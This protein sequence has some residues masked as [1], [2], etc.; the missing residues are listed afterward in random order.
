MSIAVKDIMTPDPA[1]C[2]PDS[3]L[4]EVAKLMVEHDCGEIPVVASADELR[5]IGVITDRD[6]VVRTLGADLDPMQRSVRHCMSTPCITVSA[7]ATLED[8]CE[9]M[10]SQQIRRVPV[11]DDDGTLVGIVAL[12]DIVNHS[13]RR[14]A[15]EVIK[16][17]SQ[18]AGK[19]H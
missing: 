4:T 13:S 11:V 12:A 1:V 7:D 9:L 18:P 3:P 8:C 14:T 2:T 10:E 6:I 15:A 19:P 16:E 5:P 17:V